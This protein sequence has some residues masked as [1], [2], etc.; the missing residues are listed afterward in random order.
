VPASASPFKTATFFMKRLNQDEIIAL[1]KKAF[2]G[3]DKEIDEWVVQMDPA[4]LQTT[5]DNLFDV[6][7]QPDAFYQS[8]MDVKGDRVNPALIGYMLSHALRDAPDDEVNVSLGVFNAGLIQLGELC[9]TILADYMLYYSQCV[10][11]ERLLL[12]VQDNCV[13]VN[14]QTY[15][16]FKA[17]GL[18]NTMILGA[19]LMD[20]QTKAPYLS[21][22]TAN[23]GNTQRTW[24]TY[25]AAA[26]M[27]ANNKLAEAGSQILFDA[28]DDVVCKDAQSLQNAFGHKGLKENDPPQMH[29]HAYRERL[30]DWIRKL[31]QNYYSAEK[32]SEMAMSVC[33]DILY[34]GTAAKEIS[35][36]LTDVR[37][38]NPNLNVREAMMLACAEYLGKFF[39]DMI[40][41]ETLVR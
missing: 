27:A 39:A 3:L 12:G 40:T 36:G 35:E 14:D 8:V 22:I 37:Q 25:V 11:S 31:P 16:K 9:A 21:D 38:T 4:H 19:A 18:A 2:P 30:K 41:Q 15:E 17:L 20:L 33:V 28:I 26:N 32:A 24:D 23:A 5:W 34:A 6:S 29:L 13:L 10:Q 1:M 7:R